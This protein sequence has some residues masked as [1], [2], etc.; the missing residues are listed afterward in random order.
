MR[1]L[2]GLTI[3]SRLGLNFASV[4]CHANDR[5]CSMNLEKSSSLDCSKR[6]QQAGSRL[7]SGALLDVVANV[8]ARWAKAYN[9]GD[10]DSLIG[11]FASD[12]QLLGGRP[13]IYEGREGIGKYF[14][15]LS[16]GGFAEFTEPTAATEVAEGVILAA[17]HIHFTRNGLTRPHRLSWLLVRGT[18]GWRIS[19][20]HASPIPSA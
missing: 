17:T 20:H 3:K 12:A 16:P 18:N 6:D 9:C 13:G 15:T 2:H 5:A 7:A 11:L 4:R 14:R 8:Q 1:M 19:G 10:W